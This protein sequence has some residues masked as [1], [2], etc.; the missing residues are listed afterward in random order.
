MPTIVRRSHA[1]KKNSPPPV[2]SRPCC[3]SNIVTT[4]ITITSP[5]PSRFASPSP[6]RSQPR[7]QSWKER[8]C[9]AAAPPSARIS[10]VGSEHQ[11]ALSLH[12]HDATECS[13]SADILQQPISPCLIFVPGCPSHRLIQPTTHTRQAETSRRR[14]VPPLPSS[15][16]GIRGGASGRCRAGSAAKPGGFSATGWT[17]LS[18]SAWGASLRLGWAGLPPC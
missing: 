7:P 13:D 5:P 15:L 4:T 9:G 10:L 16:T 1:A 17:E 6:R 14:S 11:D 2:T 18:A 8:V 3:C 12:T